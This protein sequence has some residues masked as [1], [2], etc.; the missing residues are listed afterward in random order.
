MINRAIYQEYNNSET[1]ASK[2]IKLLTTLKRGL[3]PQ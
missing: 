3:G 1:T 2:Y